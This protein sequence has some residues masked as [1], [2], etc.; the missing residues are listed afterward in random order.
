MT[1]SHEQIKKIE[2]VL[3]QRQSGDI[4]IGSFIL[5]RGLQ[6]RQYVGIAAMLEA[7]KLSQTVQ[8]DP[9]HSKVCGEDVVNM[10]ETANE[11]MNAKGTV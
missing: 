7:I 8:T 9:P 4:S 3:I 10:I 5:P 11:L 2:R 1:V 6:W